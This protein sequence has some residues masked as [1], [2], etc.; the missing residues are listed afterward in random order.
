MV[1]YTLKQKKIRL[2]WSNGIHFWLNPPIFSS[3]SMNWSNIFYFN[4]LNQKWLKHPCLFRNQLEVIIHGVLRF[5]VSSSWYFHGG[6]MWF[7]HTS[8]LQYPSKRL[9]HRDYTHVNTGG[10]YTKNILNSKQRNIFLKCYL[11]F[12]CVRKSEWPSRPPNHRK[13][14]SLWLTKFASSRE[15]NWIV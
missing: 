12:I 10:Y 11:V 9:F 15:D 3:K 1:N 6:T 4:H 2:K 5:L 7:L 8:V 14:S 13:L